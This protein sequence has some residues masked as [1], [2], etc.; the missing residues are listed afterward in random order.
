VSYWGTSYGTYLGAVYATL[1][2]DRT[3]RMLLDS[4]IDPTRIW[5]GVIRQQ[6]PGLALRFPDAARYA[7][8]FDY[9]ALAARLDA[10]P[11]TVPGAGVMTGGVF[12]FMTVVLLHQDAAIPPLV[13]AWQA[14]ADL[15]DG[16][17]LDAE[18]LELMREIFAVLDPAAGTSPGVPQDNFPAAAY[19][20]ACDDVR[21]PR[22]IGVYTRNVAADVWSI[23]SRR[24]ARRTCGPPP[25]GPRHP[26][27]HRSRSPPTARATF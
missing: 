15:A 23:R 6:A 20:V 1:F 16:R 2:R 26:S 24:A 7:P 21:W 4:A 8:G 5:Y 9:L 11:V 10:H 18:N 17:P 25:S 12:R 27:S 22:D 13:Q 3:D 19:A 14:T